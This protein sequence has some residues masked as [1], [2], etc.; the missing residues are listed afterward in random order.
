MAGPGFV[1]TPASIRSMSRHARSLAP[2]A[3]ILLVPSQSLPE[4][5]DRRW[6]EEGR[7]GEV[8]VTSVERRKR[9]TWRREVV[10]LTLHTRE[11]KGEVGS[12]VVVA[13]V[14]LIR[15]VIV[16]ENIMVSN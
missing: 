16:R 5:Q 8:T 11:E 7:E 15:Y 12:V 13:V 4:L 9:A 14:E 1:S 2:E 6:E 10:T 3:R